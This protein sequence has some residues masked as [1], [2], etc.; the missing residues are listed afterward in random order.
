MPASELSHITPPN[1]TTV[2][3]HLQHKLKQDTYAGPRSENE[4]NRLRLQHEFIK[5]AM[6]GA[7]V[8]APVD[9]NS[10]SLRVLDSATGDGYWLVDLSQKLEPS[11][12][13]IGADIALQHSILKSEL[14]RNVS[15]IHHNIFDRWA[16]EYRQSFDLVHQRFVLMACNDQNSV[17]AIRRLFECIKPG[18]WIQLHDGDMDTIEDG[19]ENKAMIK[20]R[21]IARTGW[22]TLGFNLSP[23]PK[24]A[25]WL[26]EVGAVDIE[27]RVLYIKCG[28]RS[29]DLNQGEKV[30]Q[31]L[32]A[33][34]DNMIGLSKSTYRR[35]VARYLAESIINYYSDIPGFPYPPEEIEQL[36]EDMPEE[37]RRVGNCYRTHVVWARKAHVQ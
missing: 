34:L 6:D 3:S 9:M 29:P 31:M 7:L 8:L 19:P 35:N 27:D 15:L 37:L 11:S 22:K 14:P 12:V 26:K 36:K 33:S 21:E 28:K 2:A 16:D 20:F 24:L 32:V 4:Y 23:G 5:Y 25:G 1:Q 30:I 18:G 17:E 10:P 13:L